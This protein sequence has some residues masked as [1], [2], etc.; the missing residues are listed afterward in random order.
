MFLLILSVV[1]ILKISSQNQKIFLINNRYIGWLYK[2]TLYI[3]TYM[4]RE[5][6]LK[7]IGHKIRRCREDAGFS[8][9][10][11][12]Y[13]AEI[14]RSYYAGIERG[15]HNLTV[16]KLIHIARKLKIDPCWLLDV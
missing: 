4:D 8:Q 7:K 6:T 14:A 16:L 10:D 15:E 3:V 13:Y 11:F 12:A 2:Y 5:R 1:Q 9:D